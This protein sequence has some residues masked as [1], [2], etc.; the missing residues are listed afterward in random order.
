MDTDRGI[1]GIIKG[2]T[3]KSEAAK[4]AEAAARIVEILDGV[5]DRQVENIFTFVQ[6]VRRTANGETIAEIKEGLD[7]LARKRRW[8]K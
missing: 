8:A 2:R 5:P 6:N 1:N 4:T 3:E 7:N